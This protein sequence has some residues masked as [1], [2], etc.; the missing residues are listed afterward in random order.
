MLALGFQHHKKMVALVCN[1]N[2]KILSKR[3]K[4]RER[5]KWK[6]EERQKERRI[7]KGKMPKILFTHVPWVR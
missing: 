7:I 3:K 2:R 5:E 6:K 4:K 1:L